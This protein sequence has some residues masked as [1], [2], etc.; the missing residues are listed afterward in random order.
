MIETG[1]SVTKRPVE[2]AEMHIF[3]DVF[4]LRCVE[5]DTVMPV[6]ITHGLVTSGRREYGIDWRAG[7]ANAG[8]PS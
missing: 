7:D 4:P 1:R 3:P 6:G 2:R 5:C 8:R